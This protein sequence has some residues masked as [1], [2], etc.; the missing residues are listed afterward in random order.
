MCAHVSTLSE[1]FQER[2]V[3]LNQL[4]PWVPQLTAD[5][6]E[7]GVHL[8]SALQSEVFGRMMLR[9]FQYVR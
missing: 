3:Q 2:G 8:E 1:N 9:V 4:Y 7:D 5:V 6:G